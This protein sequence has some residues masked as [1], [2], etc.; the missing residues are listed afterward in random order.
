MKYSLDAYLAARD[1]AIAIGH[2]PSEP[3]G[4]FIVRSKS[5]RGLTYEMQHTPDGYAVHQGEGC[6]G[7]I[8]NGPISCWHSKQ[9]SVSREDMNDMTSTSGTPYQP[10]AVAVAR[11]FT[12]Q[13]VA[14]LKQTICK[15]AS[16]AELKLFI[17]TCQHTGLD[18]FMRQ[19]YAVMRRSQVNGQWV[20]AMTIQIGID[21]FR[22]VANRT[23]E[24]QGMDGP[25]WTYDGAT[26]VDLPREDEK[27]LAARCA[28]WR[29]GVE[30]AFIAVCRWSA[31]VQTISSGAPNSM[32][33]RM[34]PEMLAKCAEA[35]A[36]RRAFPAEMA[37]LPSRPDFIDG[38]EVEMERQVWTPAPD[39]I[40][41]TSR[42]VHDEE[43]ETPE[44]GPA[45]DNPQQDED[46]SPV[47]EDP[48][49]G[50]TTIERLLMDCKDTWA[51]K[52]YGVLFNGLVSFMPDGV[53][54]F[55]PKKVA[56]NDVGPCLEHIRGARG[57]LVG[58][59]P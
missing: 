36:L 49:A 42:V 50:R 45:Q 8:F 58:A 37:S 26:W 29:K 21:G 11:E 12:D 16:D 19:I 52:D 51:P 47:L 3:I 33:S 14:T 7:E 27:P 9:H 35:L 25:Q 53:K 32:W 54:T 23:G 24:M 30:R 56:D 46:P 17:A 39:A 34:G 22:L 6:E 18:P 31:Y 20:N 57:E 1:F 13:D 44:P 43:P 2:D 55:D 15:G 41:S 59:A 10:G 28:V 38:E 48:N 40:E 4:T 5:R